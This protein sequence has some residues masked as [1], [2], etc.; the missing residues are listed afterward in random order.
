MQ[1][2]VW[3]SLKCTAQQDK[4]G[5]KAYENCDPIYIYKEE[6]S[7]PPLGYVDDVLTI[8]KCGNDAVVN[9]AIVN[10]F[11]ESKK[12]EYNRKKCKKIHIGKSI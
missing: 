10:A 2:T 9:N 5:K 11:T 7:V 8:A 3:A 12:L 1:G 4:L 6:V